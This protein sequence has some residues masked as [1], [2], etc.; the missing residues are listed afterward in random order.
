[1]TVSVGGYIGGV[2]AVGVG[3]RDAKRAALT[4]STHPDRQPRLQRGGQTGG[5]LGTEVPATVS[6][7][8]FGEQTANQRDGL[9]EHVE[10]LAGSREVIPVRRGL[11]LMPARTE[12]QFESP[13][14]DVVDRH[15]CLG[16]QAGIPVRHAKHETAE[17]GVTSIGGKCTKGGHGLEVVDGAT[18]WRCFVKMV[19][20]RDPVGA[21]V[22]ESAPQ[23]PKL[24]HRQVLLA[25]VDPERDAHG[26]NLMESSGFPLQAV[27][28]R[29]G[30]IR[31]GSASRGGPSS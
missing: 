9:L 25:D 12:P 6:R 22:V 15:R 2:P 24:G 21:R 27:D 20:H 7:P 17:P 31:K 11:P 16:E 23:G 28:D 3:G 10:S 30:S 14:R 5:I 13:A 8:G 18:R 26:S 4:R 29:R 19:P 1:M